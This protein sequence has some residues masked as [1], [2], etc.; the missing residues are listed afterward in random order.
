MRNKIRQW[1]VLV[2]A[3]VLGSAALTQAAPLPPMFRVNVPYFA[4]YVHYE[5]TGVFW[6][7]YVNSTDNYA[8]V[9]MGY[10][11]TELYVNVTIFDRWLWYDETPSAN[12]LTDWDA[13]SL[14]VDKDGNV[15]NV[16][17]AN[18]YRFDGQ[19]T[20]WENPRTDWQ[21]AYRGNGSGWASSTISFTTETGWAGNAPNHNEDDDRGWVITFHIPFASLGLSGP[22]S[23]GMLW[24]LGVVLHDRDN[25]AGSPP[26]ADKVW[27]TGMTANQPSSWGQ[28]RFGLP[29][30]TPQHAIRGGTVTV[31]QGL[32]GATVPDAAVGGTVGNMC[33]GDPNVIWN[34]WG[35]YKDPHNAQV[36]IHNLGIVG[37]WPCVAKYYV[38]FPLSKVPTGKV[39][40]SATLV[41]HQFGNDDPSQAQPSFI[42]A[43]T[44]GQSWD[45]NTLTWN[46]APPARENIVGT[47]VTPLQGYGGDPGVPYT[48]DVSRAAAEAY[49]AGEPLRLALYPSDWALN[50]GKYFW[51]S[52]HEDWM[53]EARPTLTVTWGDAA[54]TLTKRATSVRA[55]HGDVITYSL[56]FLG[57]GQTLVITDTLPSAL[58]DPLTMMATFGISQYNSSTR[59]LTWSAAPSTGQAVT[60]TYAVT[61]TRNG[62]LAISNT[63]TLAMP[64]NPLS[65]STAWVIVD[66]HAVWLPLIRR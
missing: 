7:G 10:D 40:I 21:A 16:P 24:G 4:N 20:W 65:T 32:N 19:L 11:N 60:I 35:N 63:A 55:M 17:D 23:Q 51:S 27:P 33:P 52:D 46:T 29:T 12:T 38:D 2:F 34:Q 59:Q 6:F 5:E 31:R 18:A 1:V 41:M 54:A 64:G 26:I 42:Q 58:S 30:Y 15:S 13:V 8:D 57:A 25:A 62:P 53:A 22:P 45:E 28:L 14:Y 50:G 49:V 43:L 66:G 47:W 48:W 56:S 61:V 37:D 36:V 44:V 3:L 39:I 9:R